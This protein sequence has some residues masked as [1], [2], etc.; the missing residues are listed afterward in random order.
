MFVLMVMHVHVCLWEVLLSK[1]NKVHE[2][3][4][5][6]RLHCIYRTEKKKKNL[7]PSTTKRHKGAIA[8]V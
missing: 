4:E 8:A 2:S 3:H 6:G 5:V 1:D 7:W